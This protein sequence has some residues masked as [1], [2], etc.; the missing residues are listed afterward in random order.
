MRRRVCGTA[1]CVPLHQ[2]GGNRSGFT[3][4]N[5]D[6]QTQCFSDGIVSF[7]RPRPSETLLESRR[8]GPI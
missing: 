4:D 3:H 2:V 7:H 6:D 1:A 5:F 8:I